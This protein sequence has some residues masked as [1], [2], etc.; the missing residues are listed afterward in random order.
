MAIR[1]T[2][3]NNITD[4]TQDELDAQIAAGNYPAG[5]VLND[6]VLPSDWNDDHTNPDI[7]DVTGLT[8]AL[9]ARVAANGAITGAT[10]TKITYDA[11]GLV[12]AGADATTADIADSSNKRYVTDSQL[13]V[14]GNTSGTNTGDQTITLTGEVTGSGTGSFATTLTNSSVIGKVLTGYTSAAGTVAATDTILQAIQKLNGNDA[15][16]LP[17]SGGTLTGNL[18]FSADNTKDIG[19]SGAN[20]ARTLYLGTSAVIGTT[21]ADG[22]VTL[23]RSSDGTAMGF[24]GANSSGVNLQ[25]NI[26]TLGINSNNGIQHNTNGTWMG[27]GSISN[28]TPTAIV[29]LAAGA[30]AASSAP[31]KFSSGVNL[32]TPE[33]GAVE[34]DG[35]QLYFSPSTTRQALIQDNGTRLTSGR[36][37]FAGTSGYL[38]DSSALTFSAGTLS[39]TTFSGAGTGLT[40]TAA[41]LS[42]GGN[43]ATVTTNANLTGEVTSVGNA[44][45]LT[46][47]A[48]IGKVL[49][50]YVSGSGTVAATDTI[51]QAIQKLNGN[52][53]LK[54]PIAS[55]T[56]TGTVSG[57]TATM[58]GLGNVTNDTQTKAAIVP[59]TAPSAG[60][61]LVGNAGGTAYAPV[62]V[63]SEATLASTGAVTLANSAVIGKVLT[64]YTSGAGTVA[65]TDTILQAIQKLNGNDALK[66][67]SGGALGTPS[68]GT[69][70]NCTGLPISTGV[71]GLGTGVATFLATPSSA[72]FAAA[73]TDESGTAGTVPLQSSITAWT[74]VLTFATP[75][76][77]SVAYAANGQLGSYIRTGNQV[78]CSFFIQ[79]STFT[80]TTASGNL[81]IT[82]QPFTPNNS[83]NRYGIGSMAF[84][85]ITKTNYTNFTPFASPGSTII[86]VIASGSG[87]AVDNVTAAN[88]PTGGTVILNG[89]VTFFI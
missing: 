30:A 8:A 54:A 47:S 34:Y 9:D 14:I 78:T 79:T 1:H 32:T 40:G 15:L 62:A 16:A 85:G 80:F 23:N 31:L 4:W 42:I 44:A 36:V 68:S 27:K 71:S 35:T 70:T 58:V 83:T 61:I 49:T 88:M 26:V 77:L 64:G 51:L 67:T 3:T 69:L 66:V 10:K 76:N 18:L 38:Q 60:Q 52:D 74:P 5:T 43:A 48:V 17:L 33:A 46:N 84:S 28:T 81:Q 57:I 86:T 63:S 41:S 22:K 21:G 73:L 50:G 89:S 7:A 39:A 65:A 6:I 72:N 20:R 29:H 37:P 13:V 75:G 53:A 11:K 87:Q 59:N 82:G 24:L 25:G 12:T 2:K 56:F 19:A 45:T 55:P